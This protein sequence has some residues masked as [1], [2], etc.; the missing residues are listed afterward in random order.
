MAVNNNRPLKDYVVAS[1]YEPH[2]GI[3][4]SVIETNNFK[5]KPTLVQMVQ[6]ETLSVRRLFPRVLLVKY[7]G[8]CSRRCT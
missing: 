5:L 7:G 2:A 4:S 8:F 3:I 1:Q 6:I